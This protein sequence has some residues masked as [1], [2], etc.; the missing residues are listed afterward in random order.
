MVSSHYLVDFQYSYF[1]ETILPQ[2]YIIIKTHYIIKCD[3]ADINL[4]FMKYK[5]LLEYILNADIWVHH[6]TEDIV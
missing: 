4:H 1:Q 6:H 3:V 2:F 5:H